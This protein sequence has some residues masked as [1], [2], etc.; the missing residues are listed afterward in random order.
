MLVIFLA[1]DLKEDGLM[2]DLCVVWR[3][4]EGMTG[5]IRV[6]KRGPADA[7]ERGQGSGQPSH[8]GTDIETLAFERHPARTS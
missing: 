1:L 6:G 8:A 2:E 7:N 4:S 5:V 3:I